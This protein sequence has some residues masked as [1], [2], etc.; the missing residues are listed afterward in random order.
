MI[1]DL[2]LGLGLVAVFEG[3][4]LALAPL[5]FDQLLEMLNKMT[6][7]QRRFLGLVVV[8]LGVFVVWLSKMLF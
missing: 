1:R 7:G 4:V 6:L 8:A 2:I 3:L 5:R